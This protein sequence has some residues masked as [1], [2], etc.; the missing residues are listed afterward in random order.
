MLTTALLLFDYSTTTVPETIL[1]FNAT[2]G[3]RGETEAGKDN[4]SLAW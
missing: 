2:A 4:I 3:I 1:G